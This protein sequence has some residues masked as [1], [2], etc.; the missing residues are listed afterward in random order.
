MF[1]GFICWLLALMRRK[2]MSYTIL[3]GL[4]V[5]VHG[6]ERNCHKTIVLLVTFGN[7]ICKYTPISS[8][9]IKCY[10]DLRLKWHLTLFGLIHF[11]FCFQSF[12]LISIVDNN[13]VAVMCKW[14][15]KVM[16]LCTFCCCCCCC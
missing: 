15:L 5:C 3:D 8:L 2:V 1:S 13:S 10:I 4:L 11:L 7:R 14:K 12:K 6:V 16:F 9:R